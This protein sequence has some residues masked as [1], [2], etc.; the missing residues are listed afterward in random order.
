MSMALDLRCLTVLLMMPEA[1][2][3][4]VCMG[5]G[6]CGC[7]ISSSEFLSTS[8]SL[9]L[10]NRPP[11]SASAAEAITFFRM[12]DTTNIASLCLVCDVGL[13]LSLRKKSPPPCLLPWMLTGNM[14]HC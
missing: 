10:M 3:L 2:E 4:S 13:N 8:L 11:N 5:I 1:M 12:D 9:V 6:P 7:P 14:H